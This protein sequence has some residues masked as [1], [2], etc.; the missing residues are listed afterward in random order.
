M[1]GGRRSRRRFGARPDGD[2]QTSPL[3]VGVVSGLLLLGGAGLVVQQLNG[4]TARPEAPAAAATC[5]QTRTVLVAT[6]PALSE[7][8]TAATAALDAPCLEVTVRTEQPTVTESTLGPEDPQRP[9]LWALDSTARL[10][11]LPG[12]AAASVLVDSLASSPLLLVGGAEADAPRTWAAAVGSGTFTGA[13]PSDDTGTLLALLATRS[14]DDDRATDAAVRRLARDPAP[15][16][17]LVPTGKKTRALTEQQFLALTAAGSTAPAT[18]PT[19][20]TVA[21]DHPLVALGV[22][23]Q[24]VQEVADRLRDWFASA[25]GRSAL[26]QAH[27][28][29]AAG[30]ALPDSPVATPAAPAATGSATAL[31]ADWHAST[32]PVSVLAV[33]DASGSMR[34]REDGGRRTEFAAEG[35]RR[36]V[37]SLPADSRMGLWAFAN[38]Q[39]GPGK[40][41]DELVGLGTL[42]PAH[43]DALRAACDAYPGTAGGGTSLFSTTLR[44]YRAAVAAWRPDVRNSVLL[45][46]DGANEDPDSIDL[47]TLVRTLQGLAAPERPV[48]VHAIGISADAD[49]PALRRIT[50]ATGGSAQ[51][52]DSADAILTAARALLE[53]D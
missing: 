22:V 50:A 18:V 36:L 20:G 51:Q 37:D 25:P 39:G 8:L 12:T 10:D 53:V 19:A 47:D 35:G 43:G 29:T 23:D 9:H 15:A 31:V 34:E 11:A 49:M 28:R 6:V 42:G 38:D 33:L 17:P 26:A 30:A 46:T 52:A 5:Q 1:V 4:A 45:I 41:W 14:G 40:D 27:L 32:L 7:P 16:D 21:A 44:A 2:S 13:D 24:G 48:R 3:V